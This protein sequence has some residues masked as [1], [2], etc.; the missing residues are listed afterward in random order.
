M[1]SGAVVGQLVPGARSLV[2]IG[3]LGID[4]SVFV[5]HQIAQNSSRLCGLW[6]ENLH[7]K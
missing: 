6:S 7:G 2:R 5:N 1:A 4:G 3:L